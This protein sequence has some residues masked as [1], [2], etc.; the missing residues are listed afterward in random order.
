MDGD[1]AVILLLELYC[2]PHEISFHSISAIK[3]VVRDL[4]VKWH[5]D[6]DDHTVLSLHKVALPVFISKPVFNNGLLQ[7]DTLKHHPIISGHRFSMEKFKKSTSWG[8]TLSFAEEKSLE[9]CL[10][11]SVT[12]LKPESGH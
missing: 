1:D 9:S 10:W 6:R 2:C 12:V 4:I 5:I 7:R 11:H 3:A 8:T